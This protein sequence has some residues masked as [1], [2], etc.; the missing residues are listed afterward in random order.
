MRDRTL[1]HPQNRVQHLAVWLMVFIAAAFAG[2]GGDAADEG[3]SADGTAATGNV[4]TGGDPLV[5]ELEKIKYLQS[6][7]HNRM[8]NASGGLL[9]A[10]DIDGDGFSDFI[11]A[12]SAQGRG[13]AVDRGWIEA[14][15]GKDGARLWQIN[16]K[17]EDEA[18]ALGD[19]HG[20]RLE[21]ITLVGDINGDGVAD[22]FARPGTGG[23]T[24][25]LFSGRDGARLGRHTIDRSGHFAWP[26]F[27][28]DANSDGIVDLAF[29]AS[30]EQSFGIQVL[31]GTDL[32]PLF[33]RFDI[34]P[35]ANARSINWVLPLYSDVNGDGVVD[36]LLRRGL[37]QNHTDEVYTF[38]Y[39]VLSGTDLTI[40]KT[41]ESERP[42][43]GG[44]THYAAAGDLN[45][46][47]HVDILMTSSTG[48]GEDR[49]ASSIRAISG[50]DGAVLWIVLGTQFPGGD[51]TFLV[52]TQTGE[53][54]ALQ[55]D[56]EF[57]SQVVAVPDIDGDGVNEAAT[58]AKPPISGGSGNAV[59]MFSG[60][61]GQ[62]FEPI[63]I[64]DGRMQKSIA[65]LQA[66]T[67][68][69]QPSVVVAAHADDGVKMVVLPLR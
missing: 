5:V 63:E 32:A 13:A 8:D 3:A 25:L 37:R 51:Q 22:V 54:T 65:V 18:K 53:Q 48:D 16:G 9:S 4:A 42:R 62:P 20:Y 39:G 59:L 35:G 38:E 56:I 34:W 49:H 52:D 2:C 7:P 11:I 36:A 46:D 28:R 1:H 40:L 19:E 64:S 21:E 33:Q 68:S 45:G 12:A 14:Y 60:A 31:S 61:T 29:P 55:P 10:G 57:G 69:R 66:A 41:F 6:P 23:S 44:E 43:I 24:T 47:G 58:V 27:A 17:S 67:E 26:L 30:E 50:A 15:S